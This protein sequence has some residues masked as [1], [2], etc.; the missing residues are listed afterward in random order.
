MDTDS[1]GTGSSVS[2]NDLQAAEAGFVQ[3]DSQRLVFTVRV[4]HNDV[5]NVL[6]STGHK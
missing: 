5:D 4:F 2:R 6:Y 1:S 3:T